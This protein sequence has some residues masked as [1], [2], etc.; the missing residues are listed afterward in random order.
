MTTVLN[1]NGSLQFSSV[2]DLKTANLQA[3]DIVETVAYYDDWAVLGEDS[4]GSAAYIIVNLSDFI[5]VTNQ[6]SPDEYGDHTLDNG[7]IAMLYDRTIKNVRQYGA[8]GNGTQDDTDYIQAALNS[9]RDA[10]GGHIYLPNGTYILHPRYYLWRTFS[11]QRDNYACVWVY[12][13]TR[14]TGDGPSTICKLGSTLPS[15]DAN[16]GRPL[17]STSHMFVNYKEGYIPSEIQQRNIEFENIKFDGNWIEESGDGI[18]LVAV[19]NFKVT[20]CYFTN[21]YYECMYIVFCRGGE[22]SHCFVDQCGPATGLYKD[23]G[24]PLIDTSSHV[25]IHD[26][27]ITDVG[28][29]SI[30]AVVAFDCIIANNLIKKE[31]YPYAAGFQAIRLGQC[32]NTQIRDNIITDSGYSAIWDHQGQNNVIAGNTVLSAGF[33]ADSGPEISGINTDDNAGSGLGRNIVSDNIVIG[34]NGGGINIVG[35]IPFAGYSEILHIGTTAKNNICLYNG[36]DGISIY[37]D[38]HRITSNILEGNGIRAESTDLYD[39]YAGVALNGCKYCVITDNTCSDF[40][41]SAETDL[42]IDARLGNYPFLTPRTVDHTVRIQNFGIVEYPAIA[43]ASR[44]TATASG[45]TVTLD[46]EDIPETEG[47]APARIGHGLSV[48][49]KI[50]VSNSTDS[51]YNGWFT[52]DTIIDEHKLTYTATALP[53]TSPAPTP[54]D[55]TPV[56]SITSDGTTCTVTLEGHGRAIGAEVVISGANESAYN[57]TFTITSTPSLNIFTY[58]ALSEPSASPATGSPV[59]EDYGSVFVSHEV[60]L[61]D[62]NIISGNNLTYNIANPTPPGTGG[63]YPF[64]NAPVICGT[65]STVNNNIGE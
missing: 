46:V 59:I 40:P 50:N 24:G 16:D 33:A 47:G 26:N 41:Q 62:Y 48:G 52:V 9:A 54:Y 51:A 8:R 64:P 38:N 14:I 11:S 42:N 36:W 49:D 44:C 23:G 3:G 21:S 39:G 20:N 12:S 13:N 27:V 60:L 25:N 22:F 53:T 2:A 1:N 7:L 6:L 37:G 29:Y 61:S 43:G 34:S 15:P 32:V 65:N 31:G 10:N 55:T 18:T 45:Y 35:S 28:Y 19:E 30:L 4:F 63:Y 57:G 58:E 5:A 17:Q 56:D